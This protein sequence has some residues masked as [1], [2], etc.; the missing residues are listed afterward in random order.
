MGTY[1]IEACS[2]DN[3]LDIKMDDKAAE[4]TE[5]ITHPIMLESLNLNGCVHIPSEDTILQLKNLC[6]QLTSL[7]ALQITV[8]T[9]QANEKKKRK[10]R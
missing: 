2:S 1:F 7:Q 9:S 5:K 3:G 6:E 4:F 8:T 10:K